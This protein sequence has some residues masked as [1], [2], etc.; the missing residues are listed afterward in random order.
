MQIGSIV[1]NPAPHAAKDA[2]I[3]GNT[4]ISSFSPALKSAMQLAQRNK[5]A[6][7]LFQS[8]T[9]S[10]NSSDSETLCCKALNDYHTWLL[11]ERYIF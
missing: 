11:Q 6:G 7:E 4:V 8:L 9:K 3:G 5:I 2:G 10:E 1:F